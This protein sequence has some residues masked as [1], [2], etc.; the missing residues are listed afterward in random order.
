MP[1]LLI[2]ASLLIGLWIIWG[3]NFC[4]PI[5]AGFIGFRICSRIPGAWRV[6]RTDFYGF[7]C[8]CFFSGSVIPCFIKDCFSMSTGTFVALFRLIALCLYSSWGIQN[9]SFWGQEHFCSYFI[10][11]NYWFRY[12][13]NFYRSH[14][15]Y[16]SAQICLWTNCL[17]HR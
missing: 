1:Y 16:S 9:Q 6:Y 11:P 10:T 15:I 12:S 17:I 7:S 8:S 14:L 5:W 3:S 2:F 4:F 13:C